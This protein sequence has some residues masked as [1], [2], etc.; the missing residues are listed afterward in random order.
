MAERDAKGFIRYSPEELERIPTYEQRTSGGGGMAAATGL[1]AGTTGTLAGAVIGSA[2]GPVGT[3]IGGLAGA[4][5]AP[6]ATA[7]I[8]RTRMK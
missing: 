8:A 7:A 4:T 1:T 6:A 5:L 2:W 3:I